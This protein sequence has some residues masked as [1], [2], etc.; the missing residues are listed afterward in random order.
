MSEAQ[1]LQPLP[2]TND[3]TLQLGPEVHALLAEVARLDAAFDQPGL[4]DD[5]AL[6]LVDRALRLLEGVARHGN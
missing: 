5:S 3:Q 6:R 2:V 1:S 4:P